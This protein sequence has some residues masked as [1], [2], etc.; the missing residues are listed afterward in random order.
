MTITLTGRERFVAFVALFQP[1]G[2]WQ[3]TD[4]QLFARESAV[5]A[6]D[7]GSIEFFGDD[8]RICIAPDHAAFAVPDGDYELLAEAAAE[9]LRLLRAHNTAGALGMAKASLLRK[10][11]A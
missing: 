10:L 5:N 9:L 7:V 2:P 4:D 3:G 11:L 8:G 1:D 6:L